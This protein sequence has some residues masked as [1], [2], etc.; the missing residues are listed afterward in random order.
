VYASVVLFSALFGANPKEE[1]SDHRY[2]SYFCADEFAPRQVSLREMAD[3]AMTLADLLERGPPAALQQSVRY[4]HIYSQTETIL[5]IYQKILSFEI[6]W[7][8]YLSKYN[9]ALFAPRANHHQ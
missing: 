6:N 2:Y 3:V 9:R 8:P 1:V 4:P 5:S 7:C